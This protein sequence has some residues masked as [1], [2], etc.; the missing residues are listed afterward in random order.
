MKVKMSSKPKRLHRMVAPP[1]CF[2]TRTRHDDEPH[3]SD[4][5]SKKLS[6]ASGF[7]YIPREDTPEPR[8]EATS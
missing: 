8:D 6:L 7:D 3:G 1:E 5:Q 2:K 4:Q